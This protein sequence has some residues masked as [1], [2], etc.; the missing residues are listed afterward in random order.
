MIPSESP[1]SA[2]FWQ[3]SDG[4]ERSFVLDGDRT[5]IGRQDSDVVI[6]DPAVSRSHAFIDR[7]DGGY[8]ITDNDSKQ[9]TLVNGE[10]IKSHVLELGDR[11]ELARKRFVLHFNAAGTSRPTDH[12]DL[13]ERSISDIQ[14]ALMSDSSILDKVSCILEFRYRWEHLFTPDVAFEQ[15]L[16]SLLKISRG[17]RAFML[18]RKGDGFGYASGMGSDGQTLSEDKF[19]TSR[20]VVSRVLKSG[21]PLFM[22]EELDRV[23]AEQQSIMAMR[24]GAVACIPLYG[25]PAEGDTPV[26]LGI[27]YVDSTKPMH[28]LTG[29]DEKIVSKLALEAAN[30]LERIELVKSI[31]QRQALEQELALAEETQKA[32]L[33]TELPEI[34]GFRFCGYSKPTRYVG[35]DFY[36]F[37]PA[38]DDGFYG[39]LGDV[40][41]KGVAASLVSSMAL[42]CLRTQLR[43]GQPLVA[44][45]ELLNQLLFETSP[46]RFV[47]LFLLQLGR[48]GRGSYLSAGHNTAF[49]YRR[50]SGGVEDIS[51]N[52]LIVGAFDF[53][54]FH[55]ASITLES[56]DVLLVYSDGLSEAENPAGTML[57][58]D[59]IRETLKESAEAGANEVEAALLDLVDVFTEGHSQSDDI[60]M[61]IIESL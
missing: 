52:N 40:S 24:L 19:Q 26:I 43:S 3:D 31:E 29:L 36:D 9:G 20:T 27:L 15:I 21:R 35:G 11:I 1:H 5:T 57:G 53:A 42:G 44:P 55:S 34:E 6:L 58:E 30:V 37:M 22:T 48:D 61:V 33:P 8:L 41:G 12:T 28:S 50:G 17:E 10:A 47:T 59:A 51:S 45:A 13:I 7:V 23:I 60:T 4:N 54:T 18:V 46:E 56:G 32:L 49:L 38:S 14:T 39:L 2:L 25:I 16:S